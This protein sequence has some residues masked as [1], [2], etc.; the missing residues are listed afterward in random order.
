[1]GRATITIASVAITLTIAQPAFVL[2]TLLLTTICSQ[3]PARFTL[4]FASRV[5][6]HRTLGIVIFKVAF[7]VSRAFTPVAPMTCKIL[8]HV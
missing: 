2:R 7:S 1:M 4:A 6:S 5:M 8:R 3:I